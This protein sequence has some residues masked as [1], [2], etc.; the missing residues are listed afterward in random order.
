MCLKQDYT[1]AGTLVIPLG[2][3][4][5]SR[6]LFFHN[7]NEHR[8]ACL[9]SSPK[10]GLGIPDFFHT[11]EHF[12]SRSPNLDFIGIGPGS[13]MRKI[14]LSYLFHI[15]C[16]VVPRFAV[17]PNFLEPLYCKGLFTTLAIKNNPIE[18]LASTSFGQKVRSIFRSLITRSK[19][20]PLDRNSGSGLIGVG[21]VPG[22]RTFSNNK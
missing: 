13:G 20:C 17:N 22:L 6:F 2:E 11:E 10:E 1:S 5:S 19:T 21:L 16:K 18:R 8:L 15:K 14:Y 3:I 4:L 12:S 9:G 7:W